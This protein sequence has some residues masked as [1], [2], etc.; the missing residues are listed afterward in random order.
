MKRRYGCR[1]L[2]ATHLQ[3][4]L[5]TRVTVIVLPGSQTLSRPM[6]AVQRFRSL[7]EWQLA[8]GKMPNLNLNTLLVFAN[9]LSAYQRL[10]LRLHLPKHGTA[11]VK[12]SVRS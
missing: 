11:N 5:L 2:Q 12:S 8:D 7:P 4:L 6:L 1:S 9:A 3:Y 10:R